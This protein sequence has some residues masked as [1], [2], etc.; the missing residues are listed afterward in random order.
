MTGPAAALVPSAGEVATGASGAVVFGAV[1][2]AVA[3]GAVDMGGIETGA[4]ARGAVGVSTGGAPSWRGS[5]SGSSERTSCARAVLDNE[6]AAR[7]VT[8]SSHPI[9]GAI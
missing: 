2:G 7:S 5:G 1:F 8:I 3:L 4:V 9:R 6:P